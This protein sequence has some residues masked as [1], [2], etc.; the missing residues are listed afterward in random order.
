MVAGRSVRYTIVVRNSGASAAREVRVCDVPGAGLTV[1]RTPKG[2]TLRNGALCWQV[3]T[4]RAGG[5]RTIV[6]TMRTTRSARTQRVTNVAQVTARGS[7]PRRAT[8]GVLAT[9]SPSS[10]TL[11][12]RAGVTG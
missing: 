1:G 3:G 9:R 6:V 12:S 4:L 2:A 5:Q 8:A 7:A 10:G 11:P